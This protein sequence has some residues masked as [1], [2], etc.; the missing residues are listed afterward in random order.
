MRARERP[1]RGFGFG[2]GEGAKALESSDPGAV[3]AASGEQTS[4]PCPASTATLEAVHAGW[5]ASCRLG[6]L[7]PFSFPA[8]S[9]LFPDRLV[10]RLQSCAVR[11][12]GTRRV[13]FPTPSRGIPPGAERG[14]VQAAHFAAI[15]LRAEPDQEPH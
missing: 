15:A 7:E 9:W 14:E 8:P 10:N 5:L 4:S 1:V 3:K 12:R 13:F 11:R 2:R 6:H